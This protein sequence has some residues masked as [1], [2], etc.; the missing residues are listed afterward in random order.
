MTD[1]KNNRGL[2]LSDPKYDK[3]AVNLRTLRREVDSIVLGTGSTVGLFEEGSGN[4]SAV[5]KDSGSDAGGDYSVVLGGINNNVAINADYSAILG[6][7]GNDVLNGVVNTVVAG[8]IGINASQSNALYAQNARLATKLRS[9]L[10]RR[11]QSL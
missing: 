2:N 3:D 11:N 8:G 1:F 6:G 10:F 9:N 7:V 5:L 4:N